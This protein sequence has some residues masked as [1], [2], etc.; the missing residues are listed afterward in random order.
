MRRALRRIREILLRPEQE[1]EVVSREANAST[2]VRYV[3]VL[4]S[5]SIVLQLVALQAVRVV[6]P[7][8][9]RIAR[10]SEYGMSIAMF[11]GLIMPLAVL[12]LASVANLLAPRYSGH[13]HT[14]RA[15]QLGTYTSTPL[16]LASAFLA[17]PILGVVLFSLLGLYWLRPFMPGARTLL[18]IPDDRLIDFML[19]HF[20]VCA[21][22]G[23]LLASLVIFGPRWAPALTSA[24]MGS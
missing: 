12:V 10:S 3:L 1:W 20:C 2:T 7:D 9:A 24:V 15:L 18:G 8:V 22:V 17:V 6:V 14:H 16:W 5:L 4:A 19:A 23:V 13:R 21:L 11:D